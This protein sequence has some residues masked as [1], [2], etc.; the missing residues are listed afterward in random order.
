MLNRT[1]KIKQHE[2]GMMFRDGD[3]VKLLPPGEH[4]FFD[5]LRGIKVEIA[6][7]REPWFEHK[8]L[9]VIASSGALN[10]L[11]QVLEVNADQ[12]AFVWIDGKFTKALGPGRYVLW[13][14][15]HKVNVAIA[16]MRTPLFSVSGIRDLVN[17]PML[18]QSATLLDLKDHE[19]ALVWVD[20]R[21]ERI[22]KPGMHALFRAY[23]DIRTEIVDSRKV[24]FEHD[25]LLTILQAPGAAEALLHFPVEPGFVG[26]VFEAGKF[27]EKL[28]S[29]NYAFWAGVG[30]IKLFAVDMKEQ[31]VDVQGQ[32]IMTADKVT[33]R[34]NAVVAYRVVDPLKAVSEIDDAKQ[35]LYREAQLA[36]RESVGTQELDALLADKEA[37]ASRVRDSLLLAAPRYGLEVLRFGV[38]DIILPG[39]MK[40]ILNKVM[41]AKKGAEAGLITRRE[42][43]ASMR[44]QANTAKILENNPTL[45]RLRELEIIEKVAEKANLTVV[46]GDGNLKDRVVKMM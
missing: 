19:R 5:P 2:R 24:R 45:M 34:L 26:L 4:K 43:T 40:E 41:L 42:E 27:T 35:A 44:M 18:T 30:K 25:Q 33:L 38:R 1:F 32:E 20:G 11:A 13:N 39:E 22:L 37:L 17:E 10:G 15:L 8:E 29:G 7:L 6:N 3:F 46:L 36:L 16:D 28:A 12:R 9:D 23:H 31:V 21:F 14:V